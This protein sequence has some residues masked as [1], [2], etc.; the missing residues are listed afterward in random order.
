MLA[1]QLQLDPDLT[2]RVFSTYKVGWCVI[3]VVSTVLLLPI[4]HQ[5]LCILQTWCK[6]QAGTV[7]RQQVEILQRIWFLFCSDL[8]NL[9][10]VLPVP[11]Q[12]KMYV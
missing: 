7:A 5:L 9:Y 11:V 6:A 3:K 10:C 12:A 4:L 2:L 8:I 1:D